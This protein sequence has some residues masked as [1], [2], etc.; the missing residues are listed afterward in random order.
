MIE[1]IAQIGKI[2]LEKQGE[3]LAVDQLIENTGYPSCVFIVLRVDGEGNTVWEGCEI[4]EC[5]SDYKK[6]L[7]RSGSSR[8]INYSPTAKITTIENTY[9]QKVVGWF[10]KVN[11]MMDY[12]LFRSIEHIL[13]QQKEAILQELKDKLSLS[14]DRSLVSLKIN[15]AYL[16]DWEPFQD[17]FLNLINEKDMELSAR[18]QVCS[19]CGERK[20]TVIG[21]LSVFRFYTLDKPGFITGG[22]NEAKAWR[23]YPVCLACKAQ[24]EEGRRFIESH[25][26]YRFYGFSYLVIPKLLIPNGEDALDELLQYLTD[27]KKDIRIHQEQADSFM[28]TEEDLLGL[29]QDYDNSLSLQL[30]FLQRVQSAERILLLIEDVLPSR[31]SELFQAKRVTESLLYEEGNHPFHFGFIRTF[32][33]SGVYDKYFLQVVEYVFHKKALSMAFFAPFF[34]EQLRADFYDYETGDWSFVNKTRQALAVMIFLEQAGVLVRKGEKTVQGKF[35]Q[36]FDTYGGQLESPEK[37]AVFLLGALTQMLLDIQQQK[38]GSKPFVKQLMGL[39]MDQRSIKGLLP[40]V[41]GKLEEYE[42]Y[43]ASHRQLAEEISHLFLS[44]SPRW[45]LSIDELNFYFACGMNLSWKVKE[46]VSNKEEK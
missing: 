34:M 10:R 14:S 23:N 37:Q 24:I 30:L 16:Y 20:D 12:P 15:G 25:L 3:G 9:E 8:G 18:H 6:Y 35:A 28:T 46:V 5:G 13:V 29:M 27:G 44:S 45:K 19:I 42:S 40:K 2:M 26:Q 43:Y 36:L 32:F 7:F 31:I 21:K 4:E 33:R 11:R 17:A 41:V 38:R 39:K 1:A 22:F